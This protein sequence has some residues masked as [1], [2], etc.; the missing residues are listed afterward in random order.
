MEDS[1]QHCEFKPIE[2]ETKICATSLE[3]MLDFMTSVLGLE[4]QIEVLTTT[5]LTSKSKSNTLVQNYTV[6]A[7]PRE[8]SVTNLKRILGKILLAGDE[9]GAKVYAVAVCH[10]DTTKW[11]R[12]YVAFRMLGTEP[13]IPVCLF[14]QADHLVWISSPTS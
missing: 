12:N 2:G 13:G 11:S 5:D 1:L 4:S 8:I 3:S 6:L 7:E 9:D 14:F 10:M